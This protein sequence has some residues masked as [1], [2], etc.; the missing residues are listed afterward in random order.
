[1]ENEEIKNTPSQHWNSE[2]YGKN[3]RFVTDY[4]EDLLK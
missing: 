2:K 3:A 4:G 1:M